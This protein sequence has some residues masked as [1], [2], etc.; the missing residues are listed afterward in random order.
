MI[1]QCPACGARAKLPDSKEGAKVRCVECERIYVAGGGGGGAR[2]SRG[3]SALPIGIGAG[4]ICL[5]L[6]IVMSRQGDQVADVKPKDV[7]TEAP[8][9]AVQ[10]DLSGWE[11]KLVKRAREFHTMAF[12][13]SQFDLQSN[14]AW[15][16]VW[17]H[18]QDPRTEGAMPTDTAG[19]GL[20]KTE[21][22]DLFRGDVLTA[23][24]SDSPDNL[25]ANWKPFNGELLI[26]SDD[27]ATIR[28]D[29]EPRDDNTEGG[30]RAIEWKLVKDGSKWK[31]WSWER[32]IS[33][34]ERAKSKSKKKKQY[35]KKTLSD[36]SKVI[37]GEPGPIDYMESTTPE[38]RLEIEELIKGLIDLELPARKLSAVKSK[39]VAHGKDAIPPLL[40]KFYLM[41][42][43]GFEDIDQAIAA[44][45]VHSMLSDITGYVTTFS[46]HEALG[47]TQERRDS[48]VRQWFGWYNRKFKRFEG[49]DEGT[50]GLEEAIGIL[51]DRER[52]EYEKTLR[53]QKAEEENKNPHKKN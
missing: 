35:A 31:A 40:T 26:E 28:L 30:T 17:A 33:D 43:A 2:A 18:K 22:I 4:V 9:A 34:A 8:I 21:D 42:E 1:I 23:M 48:G 32:F 53:R 14:I 16:Q 51:S 11:S 38:A 45:L 3:G 29:L 6:V 10:E 39:L 20:L 50:D 7:I 5:G 49:R 15:P 12:T 44:Q 36:G 46:A 24:I 47:A 37:E 19:Y 27:Q 13:R 52:R 41:N 25:A